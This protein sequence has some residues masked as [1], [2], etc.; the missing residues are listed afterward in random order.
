MSA[1]AHVPLGRVRPMGYGSFPQK[2]NGRFRIA[3]PIHSTS[4]TLDKHIPCVRSY[5]PADMQCQ[6]VQAWELDA[7]QR[8]PAGQTTANNRRCNSHAGAQ[9]E[10]QA[11]THTESERFAS[12]S[13]N[14]VILQRS[15]T[16]T[17]VSHHITPLGSTVG[18]LSFG[19]IEKI[20][21]FL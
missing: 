6:L 11:F 1:T 20:L 19:F 8:I 2:L 14:V 3:S 12:Y 9:A 7:R 18:Y 5:N 16:S 13:I 15:T 17:C 21:C 4:T 10:H